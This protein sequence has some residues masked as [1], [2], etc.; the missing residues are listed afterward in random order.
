MVYLD[1]IFK[2]CQ[3]SVMQNRD[4]AAR[5]ILHLEICQKSQY[6]FKLKYMQIEIINNTNILKT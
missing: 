2:H 4:E 6:L 5:S 1:Q 3:A